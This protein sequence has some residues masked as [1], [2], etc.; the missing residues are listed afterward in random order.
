MSQLII[1]ESSN[2]DETSSNDELSDWRRDD[3]IYV[4][5][6]MKS[7]NKTDQRL[8]KLYKVQR[9]NKDGLHIGFSDQIENLNKM[10]VKRSVISS[11]LDKEDFI[12][13][14]KEEQKIGVGRYFKSVRLNN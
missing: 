7:S 13:P 8:I 10:K 14:V 4:K 2:M 5:R 12:I 6:M 11:V 1:R 3:M 9:A